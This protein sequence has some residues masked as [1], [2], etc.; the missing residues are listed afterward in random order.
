M[1]SEEAEISGIKPS[2]SSLIVT[3]GAD[4]DDDYTDDED[5]DD[6]ETEED[7]ESLKRYIDMHKAKSAQKKAT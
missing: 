1:L 4:N 6:F 5:D 2:A 3:R 7:V